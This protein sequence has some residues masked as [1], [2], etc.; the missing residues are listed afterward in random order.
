MQG[1]GGKSATRAVADD[2]D[3]SGSR[4]SGLRRVL[5]ATRSAATLSSTAAGEGVLWR[6]PIVERE[7]RGANI[8][9]QGAAENVVRLDIAEDA[10][11]AVNEENGRPPARL[12]IVAADA[13]RD[14][15]P[16]TARS[17]VPAIG[18]AGI[19]VLAR[20]RR[21]SSRAASGVSCQSG[22]ALPTEAQ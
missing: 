16:G 11:A 3:R 20:A 6:E 19:S 21:Y 12:R 4:P 10:A 5:R 1:D 8:V 17:V 22:V 15:R 7:D 13:H 14:L 18:G 9:T 2:R